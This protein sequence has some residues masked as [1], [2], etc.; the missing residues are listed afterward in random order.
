MK[1]NIQFLNMFTSE[2]M[3]A[4]TVKKLAILVKKFDTIIKANVLFKKEQ[5]PRDKG[6]ICEIEVSVSGAILFA[7]CNEK[8]Y[9][10]AVKITITELETQLKTRKKIT[11]PYL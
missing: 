5:N 4:Y 7:S 10:L 9:E 1:T 6:M 2:C 8:N 11:K 3:E